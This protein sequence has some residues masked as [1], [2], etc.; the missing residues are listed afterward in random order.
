MPNRILGG[1]YLISRQLFQS[2]LW[3]HKPSSWN[4]IWIYLLGRVNH[5][6]NGIFKRGSAYFNFSNELRDIGPDITPDMVK[7]FLQYGRRT[8]MIDTKRS[9]KGI[10]VTILNY[11]DYQNLDAY[12]STSEAREKGDFL[13]RHRIIDPE[14]STKEVVRTTLNCNK[15]QDLYTHTSTEQSTRE[16]RDPLERSTPISK[17][18]YV[19]N[20]IMYIS[21]L[22]TKKH[23]KPLSQDEAEIY[24]Q[25][26]DS[27]KSEGAKFWSFYESKGWMVGKNPMKNWHMA[28][29]GWILR[30]IP[31]D[32]P[33]KK[34]KPQ[35]L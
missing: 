29:S 9:T 17:N 35:V 1:A 21:S 4:K 27:T 25:E 14:R 24:F 19:K 23:D 22:I 33:E 28:A 30:N 11:N 8:Q 26:H 16:A 5:S 20:G 18:V 34:Y 2:E 32:E 3:K 13:R 7:K 10:I 6:D 12:A 15:L 31:K